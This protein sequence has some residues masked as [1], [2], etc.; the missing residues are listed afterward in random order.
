MMFTK[1]KLLYAGKAKSMY[2]TENPELLIAEFRDD[3][4]AF[5][6]AKYAKLENKG[7]INHHINAWLMERLKAAGIPTHF[8]QWHSPVTSIVK[9]LTMI[10]IE[11][12]V[13]NVVAGS[14]CRRLGVKQG[15]PIYPPLYELFLKNDE[16]HDPFINE[17]HAITFGWAEKKQLEAMRRLS[18]K[19]NDLLYGFFFEAGL[20]LV[21]AKYEFGFDKEGHIT[22]GDEITPDSCRIWDKQTEHILD[23]DRFRHDMGDVVSS[24]R[25]V[26]RRLGVA[27]V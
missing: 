3:T 12:V 9:R 4:T 23:K 26:A 6:G 17:D 18:L 24:Y 13:R 25:E 1:K 2:A 27:L 22:L 10:P 16:L 11:C 7:L 20:I 5:D 8:E 19:I 21:D 14:L 15:R